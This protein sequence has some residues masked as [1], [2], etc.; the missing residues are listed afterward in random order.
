MLVKTGGKA[1]PRKAT[2]GMQTVRFCTATIHCQA[3]GLKDGGSVPL[4]SLFG[5]CIL[6]GRQIFEAIWS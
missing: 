4:A 6:L 2:K 3:S 5:G 1:Q